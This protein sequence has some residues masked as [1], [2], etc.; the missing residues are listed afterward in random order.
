MNKFLLKRDRRLRDVSLI[1]GTV[2][3][4]VDKKILKCYHFDSTQ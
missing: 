2:D 4:G 3:K 1:G